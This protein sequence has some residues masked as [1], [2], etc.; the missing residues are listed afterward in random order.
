MIRRY[1]TGHIPISENNNTTGERL[2]MSAEQRTNK[3]FLYAFKLCEQRRDNVDRDIASRHEMRDAIF[4]RND[5][6]EVL[7]SEQP[8]WDLVPVTT[9][10]H[11]ECH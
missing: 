3:Q 6:D 7:C 10:T 2:A 11:R 1:L 9:P 8:Y 4:R 5:A